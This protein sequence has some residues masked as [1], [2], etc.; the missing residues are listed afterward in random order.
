MLRVQLE[1]HCQASATGADSPDVDHCLLQT[2]SGQLTP[3]TETRITADQRERR[4][5][6]LMS[7]SSSCHICLFLFFRV[8]TCSCM[9]AHAN[10]LFIAGL[11]SCFQSSYFQLLAP[12]LCTGAEVHVRTSHI[13]NVELRCRAAASL[14]ASGENT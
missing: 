6:P 4:K 1:G 3:M 14:M 11:I 2:Q 5:V 13:F 12:Y 9:C 7:T 10:M 8:F